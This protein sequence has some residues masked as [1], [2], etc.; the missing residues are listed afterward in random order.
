M[1]RQVCGSVEGHERCSCS[2][3]VVGSRGTCACVDAVA[4]LETFV[5]VVVHVDNS[6]VVVVGTY[7]SLDC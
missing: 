7:A 6:A 5:V 1:G 4:S 3:V 2:G